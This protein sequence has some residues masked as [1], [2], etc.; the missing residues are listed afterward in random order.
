[1]SDFGPIGPARWTN[2]LGYKRSQDHVGFGLLITSFNLHVLIG[3]RSVHRHG[4]DHLI[5]SYRSQA[6]KTKKESKMVAKHRQ[7]QRNFTKICHHPSQQH[8]NDRTL[9]IPDIS[10]SI[11][12][13]HVS[14]SLNFP[15]TFLSPP[16]SQSPSKSSLINSM[17]LS[18]IVFTTRGTLPVSTDAAFLFGQR[19]VVGIPAAAAV[20]M[21][22]KVD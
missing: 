4:K 5:I 11:C 22:C 1:M 7:G 2:L 20:P 6:T 16:A 21:S 18:R 15:C 8:L 19:H 9:S 13:D 17:T 12:F 3:L 10:L 14:P